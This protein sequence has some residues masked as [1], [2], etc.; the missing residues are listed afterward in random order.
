ME[1]FVQY[2]TE[3]SVEFRKRAYKLEMII[4]LPF[5]TSWE[6]LFVIERQF[7]QNTYISKAKLSQMF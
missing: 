1:C 7:H 2:G 4:T 5:L 3:C 6:L